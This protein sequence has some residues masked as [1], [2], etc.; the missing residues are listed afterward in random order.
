MNDQLDQAIEN[1]NK[2]VEINL[3][4]LMHTEPRS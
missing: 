2:V 1:F 3:H 4:T